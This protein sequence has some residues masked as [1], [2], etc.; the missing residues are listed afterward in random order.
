MLAEAWGSEIAAAPQFS[1]AMAAVRLP[2]V[3][4][5]DRTAARSIARHLREALGI[6]AGVMVIDGGVRLRV[7]AQ[8]YNEIA[9]YQPLAG[10]GRSLTPEFGV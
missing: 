9:D 3:A 1:A 5:A 4:A 10:I 7:S 2:G 6:S 8:I